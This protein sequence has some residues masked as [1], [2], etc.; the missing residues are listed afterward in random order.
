MS[1]H[2]P[3]TYPNPTTPQSQNTTQSNAPANLEALAAH[4]FMPRALSLPLP[5]PPLSPLLSQKAPVDCKGGTEGDPRAQQERELQ[6]SSSG[7]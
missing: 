3:L 6:A 4:A 1:G 5:L 7:C 2:T